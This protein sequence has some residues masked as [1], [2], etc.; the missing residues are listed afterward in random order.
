MERSYFFNTPDGGPKYNYEATDMAR[1]HAQIIGDGVSNTDTL[2][3]LFV[4]EK[5]NM[6]VSLSAGYAFANG[7]MHENTAA[8]DLT[9]EIAEPTEDRIDRI[10]IAFDN[11]PAQRKTYAYVKKGTPSSSPVPP[12]LT[13]DSYVFEM[14]VAQVRILA[15]KSF[16]EQSE[17]TD[18]R[19][20]NTVCGYIPLHNIYRALKISPSGTAT[21]LNQSFIKTYNDSANVPFVEGTTRTIPFG[22]IREDTQGE[23]SSDYSFT[24]KQDGVYHFWA[25]IGFYAADFPVGLDVQIYLYI[26]GQNSFPLVAKV[27]NSTND[28]YAIASGLDKIHAGDEVTIR[29]L[30]YNTGGQTLY[31]DLIQQRIAKI[32]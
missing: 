7:Y 12:G 30:M 3:D 4:S 21:F 28:N 25:E 16:I 11:T 24:A 9:H 18:E 6:T 26:N 20:D 32:S 2:D 1:F 29:A 15:G 22:Q 5:T 13:R 27:F 19:A 10:I 14:S 17:I 8:M 23:I 31:P